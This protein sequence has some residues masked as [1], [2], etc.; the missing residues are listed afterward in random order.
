MI[1]ANIVLPKN[2]I[3]EPA[4]T[5]HENIMDFRSLQHD[6][7]A[8]REIAIRTGCQPETKRTSSRVLSYERGLLKT[9]SLLHKYTHGG[10][11]NPSPNGWLLVNFPMVACR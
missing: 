7:H 10:M 6:E 3:S 11:K 4:M 9:S 2:N 5:S 1:P 8:K